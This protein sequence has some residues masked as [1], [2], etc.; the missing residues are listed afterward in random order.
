MN[1]LKSSQ[2]VKQRFLTI[3][4]E[5]GYFCHTLLSYAFMKADLINHKLSSI[6]SVEK[7]ER[8]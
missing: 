3:F 1:R 2:Q 4:F 7:N 6:P 5:T 8:N